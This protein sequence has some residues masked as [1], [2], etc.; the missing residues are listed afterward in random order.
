MAP[1]LSQREGQAKLVGQPDQGAPSEGI[2][3]WAVRIYSP[4]ML[5]KGT[6]QQGEYNGVE[7]PKNMGKSAIHPFE[8]PRGSGG[9]ASAK[10]TGGAA[11]GI[12]LPNRW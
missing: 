7:S 8:H 11:N 1:E 6:E 2:V 12:V 5:P 4:P 10:G 3:G 9:H